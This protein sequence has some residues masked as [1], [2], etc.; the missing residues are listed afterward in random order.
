[1]QFLKTQITLFCL[2]FSPLRV[3]EWSY[4]NIYIWKL[5]SF[6]LSFGSSTSSGSEES[7]VLACFAFVELWWEY[8]SVI[9]SSFEDGQLSLLLP[10]EP[11]GELLWRNLIFCDFEIKNKLLS[12]KWK[13]NWTKIHNS[14]YQKRFAWI[15]KKKE[16]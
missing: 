10:V 13:K 5:T 11:I 2:G 12:L 16:K 9:S 14:K 4:M 6:Q 7:E 15:F 8:T 1:M 3:G